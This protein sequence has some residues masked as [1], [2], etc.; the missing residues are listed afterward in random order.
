L[1]VISVAQTAGNHRGTRAEQ[2]Y[3]SLKTRLLEGDLDPGDTVSVTALSAQL[4]CSR[5]PVM[6][7]LKRLEGDGFI[8]IVPQVG[9][10]VV[11][12]PPDQIRDFFT[13]FARAE[14]SVPGFAAARRNQDDLAA[15]DRVWNDLEAQLERAD[16]PASRDPIYRRLNLMFFGQIHAIA[17]SPIAAGL[18]A[19][20]WDRSDFYIKIAFGSLYFSRDVQASQRRIRRAIVE[21]AVDD[22]ERHVRQFLDTVGERVA[23]RLRSNK[24]AAD[25]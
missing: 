23:H 6:E 11:V 21:G 24:V 2:A 5:V 18:A 1:F 7:A 4:D 13:L 8:R 22:A 12:P 3:E 19:G 14:A 25:R 20:M 16:G 15:L 10:R 9:C 17:R